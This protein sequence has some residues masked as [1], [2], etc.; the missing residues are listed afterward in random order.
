MAAPVR[1]RE[2]LQRL[3][4]LF[5]VRGDR[6]VPGKLRR[7]W[8]GCGGVGRIMGGLGVIRGGYRARGWTLGGAMA[9]LGVREGAIGV[10]G[11]AGGIMRW[12]EVP[13]RGCRG[14]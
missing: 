14:P 8:G 5:Q 9:V 6:G 13:W 1:D 7:V 2:A 12:L 3:S 10:L 11:G 4:F